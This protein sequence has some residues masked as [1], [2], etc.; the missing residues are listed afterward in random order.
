MSVT[1]AGAA[2]VRFD[3]SGASV[4]VTGGTSGIGAGVAAA[5]RQAG[6]EVTIT[7]TRASA[8]DYDADLAGYRYL[9][10][11][12]TDAAQ[13]AAVAA[14]LPRLDSFMA[15]LIEAESSLS[16]SEVSAAG[17]SSR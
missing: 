8:K 14:A 15:R 12:V 4:L 2:G 7:G 1:P 11:D 13:I 6:A 17:K 9:T 5:Y 3:Y 10:L 16:T